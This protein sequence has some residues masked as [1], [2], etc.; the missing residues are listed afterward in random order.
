MS[1]RIETA[2]DGS[3]WEV[4]DHGGGR[5]TRTWIS[6][7]EAGIIRGSATLTPELIEGGSRAGFRVRGDSSEREIPEL[8]EHETFP[9]EV[10]LGRYTREEIDRDLFWSSRRDQRES[11]GFLFSHPF[12][13]WDKTI[14]IVQS[15]STGDDGRGDGTIVLDFDAWERAER[16]I[17]ADGFDLAMVGDWHSHP[18]GDSVPSTTDLRA[19]LGMLDY[20]VKR[21][22]GSPVHVGL[23]FSPRRS[24]DTYGSYA[25]WVRPE[26]RGWA[27]HRT[28]AGRPVCDSVPVRVLR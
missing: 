28:H 25:D 4:I 12:R 6:G 18:S 2:P 19:W 24:W 20:S 27:T 21:G 13:S 14:N 22:S 23:I 15:T 1:T 10:V 26:V 9:A 11:G 17:R 16:A 8:R 3:R 5:S 7:G